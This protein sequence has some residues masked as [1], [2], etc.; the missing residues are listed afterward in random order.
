MGDPGLPAEDA[1]DVV[2]GFY[3]ARD[4]PALVQVELGSTTEHAFGGLGWEVVPG[5][6]AHFLVAPLADVLAA[7]GTGGAGVVLEEDLPRVRAFLLLD[8]VEVA[9]GRG[10]VDDGWLAVHGL[11]V[12]PAYRR[13]GHATV[14]MAALLAWGAGQGAATVLLHVE[15]DNTPALAMY[16]ALG[17]R[18]HHTCRYLRAG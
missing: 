7:V 8:G 9:A 4:R 2:A 10:A 6:D 3:A 15:T 18:R 14:L 11:A 1:A 12:D 5:G 17:F 16:D 13:Q